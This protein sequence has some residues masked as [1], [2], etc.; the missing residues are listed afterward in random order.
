MSKAAQ[1]RHNAQE[2]RNLARRAQ[3]EQ[4]RAQ[5]LRM[6]EAWEDF[7]QEAERA[8]RAKQ[9]FNGERQ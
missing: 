5:L 2:C 1:H 7:A 6:A 8:E 3:N 9:Q 4:H